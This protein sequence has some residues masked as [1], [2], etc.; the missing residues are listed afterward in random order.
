VDFDAAR[1]LGFG[2]GQPFD[3]Q[4]RFVGEFRQFGG[5]GRFFDDY[6]G[7]AL[8]VPENQEGYLAEWTETVQPTG[9][10]DP[11]SGVFA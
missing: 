2:H 4:D 1:G 3:R 6:L 10:F 8:G 9:Q 5:E 7:E 11:L